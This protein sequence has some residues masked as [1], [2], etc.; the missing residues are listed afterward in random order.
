VDLRRYFLNIGEVVWE[1]CA[2]VRVFGGEPRSVRLTGRKH[3]VGTFGNSTSRVIDDA[4]HPIMLGFAAIF[5][6]QVERRS[7]PAVEN[8]EIWG[9]NKVRP[10]SSSALPDRTLDRTVPPES[11]V[12]ETNLRVP[13]SSRKARTRM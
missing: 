8:V 9:G 7:I 13:R 10:C 3:G 6:S 4:I 12:H 1:V 11:K 5:R 2:E